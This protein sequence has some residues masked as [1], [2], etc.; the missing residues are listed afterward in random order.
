M[1]EEEKSEEQLEKEAEAQEAAQAD[2]DQQLGAVAGMPRLAARVGDPHVCPMVDVLKPHVGGPIAPPG[3][4]T[5]LIAGMPAAVV[6]N[7]AVCVGPIDSIAMGSATVMIG[8]RPAARL[9]DTTV[10]GGVIMM[11]APTVMIGG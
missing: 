11:G 4:P 6:G 3:V 9:L 7:P 5:V 1:A 2:F 8:G 10:H